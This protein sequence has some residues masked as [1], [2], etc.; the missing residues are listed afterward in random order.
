[1][2][3]L[4]LGAEASL[5]TTALSLALAEGVDVVL[6]DAAGHPLGRFMG[7]Q[8]ASVSTIR[9]RQMRFTESLHGTRWAA[10][11]LAHRVAAQRATLLWLARHHTPLPPAEPGFAPRNA[12][13]SLEG[14]E[15]ALRHEATPPCLP[16]PHVLMGLEGTA[17]RHYFGAWGHWLPPH[18]WAGTRTRRPAQ[19][20][21]NALLNYAL[22][23][24]L[25][26]VESATHAAGLDPTLGALH[27]DEYNRPSFALD[28]LELHRHLA[29]QAALQAALGGSLCPTQHF[30]PT[31]EGGLR[32]ARQAKR[33][34]A[35]RL[36]AL[37]A[38][39]VA[40]PP[41]PH[42]NPTPRPA[43][44]R[45]RLAWMRLHLHTLAQDLL[46]AG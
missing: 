17:A 21:L 11:L 33:E 2:R 4:F 10:A 34:L 5:S 24:L 13:A 38:E 12:L 29:E 36:D 8:A 9:R 19:D 32:L 30:E 3:A 43:R 41:F 28:I 18:W 6:T 1:V 20:P 39:T 37:L 35:Q 23:I 42:L 45:S 31:Q 22:A 44:T 7:T 40:D 26:E 25:A 14:L 46:A 15:H 27:A 16:T